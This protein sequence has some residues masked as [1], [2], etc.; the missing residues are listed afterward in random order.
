MGMDANNSQRTFCKQQIHNI[1]HRKT[2]YLFRIHKNQM[3]RN[4]NYNNI[5]HTKRNMEITNTGMD[6]NN[7]QP[8]IC[9]QHI[10]NIGH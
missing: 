9:K 6:A 8:K 1:G 7:S 5:N 10:C 3:T 4:Y 2:H